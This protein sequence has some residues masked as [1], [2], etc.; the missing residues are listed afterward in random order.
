MV[1]TRNR[2]RSQCLL[3]V[4]PEVVIGNREL[5]KCRV[6]DNDFRND[7]LLF[8]SLLGIN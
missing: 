3:V 6:P 7:G 4:I 8:P 5:L 2:T 1:R